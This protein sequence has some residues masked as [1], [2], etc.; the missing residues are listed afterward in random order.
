MLRVRDWFGV[1]VGAKHNEIIQVSGILG[2]FVLVT[3]E[4]VSDSESCMDALLSR[5]TKR[6]VATCDTL[7]ERKGK[8]VLAD[9]LDQFD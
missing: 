6:R 8:T 9:E 7:S 2:E 1:Q 5:N 3:C 4:V